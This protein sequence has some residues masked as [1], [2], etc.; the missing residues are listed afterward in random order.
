MMQF[1]KVAVNH[2]NHET[3]LAQFSKK[4][5]CPSLCTHICICPFFELSDQFKLKLDRKVEASDITEV[6]INLQLQL[7][8]TYNF[9]KTRML[10]KCT[11]PYEGRG[12][13]KP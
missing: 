12:K 8:V 11:G 7:I 13:I 5:L 1:Y 3:I 9:S 4:P 2:H 10:G 6:F